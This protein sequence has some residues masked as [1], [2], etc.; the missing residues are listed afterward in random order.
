MN[1]LTHLILDM[2]AIL[3]CISE[4]M[5]PIKFLNTFYKIT[6]WWMQQNMLDGDPTCIQVMAWC[7]LATNYYLSQCWPWSISPYG[8]SRPQNCLLLVWCQ[9]IIWASADLLLMTLKNISSSWNHL[10][11]SLSYLIYEEYYNHWSWSYLTYCGPLMPC[12]DT[13]LC[14]HLLM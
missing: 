7:C 11:S 14:Q 1:W 10:L 9:T 4:R 3:K 5:L 8:I 12:C 6:L 2:F 13:E